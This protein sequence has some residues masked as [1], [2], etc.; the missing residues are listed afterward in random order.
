MLRHSD[1]NSRLDPTREQVTCTMLSSK[2]PKINLA[3]LLSSPT[4]S[5]DLQHSAFLATCAQFT[6]AIDEY[7][8]KGREEISR[9]RDEHEGMLRR[10][11]ERMEGMEK[12][13]VE[14]RAKEV[15]LLKGT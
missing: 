4:P 2:A 5:A 3:T 9:R 1:A 12:E 15:E 11:K 7:V 13:T 6:R 10:E 14:C 8:L